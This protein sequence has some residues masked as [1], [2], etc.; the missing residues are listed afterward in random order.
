MTGVFFVKQKTAYD[1]RISDWSADV[2][3]SDLAG[4]HPRVL[5][6]SG[7]RGRRDPDAE[8][9]VDLHRRR[10][11]E[12]TDGAA[13]PRQPAS[14]GAARVGHGSE[15]RPQRRRHARSSQALIEHPRRLKPADKITYNTTPPRDTS[16]KI[17]NAACR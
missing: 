2:C 1:M 8:I 9:L 4:Q 17:E 10:H 7:C 11:G 12:R 3:S 16:K 6:A 5:P 15:R 13:R 14:T